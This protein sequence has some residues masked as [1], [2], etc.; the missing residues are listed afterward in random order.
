M[1]AARMRVAEKLV[2]IAP[3]VAVGI[4]TAPSIARRA[5]RR[6]AEPKLPEVRQRIAVGVD[7]GQ[8]AQRQFESRRRGR[9]LPRP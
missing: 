2:T 9:S 7:G 4:S 1:E 3:P 8:Q 6:Q 5:L